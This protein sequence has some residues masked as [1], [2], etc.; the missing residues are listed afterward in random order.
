MTR[1][2]LSAVLA[3]LVAAG[4][5][6]ADR[7]APK[8]SPEKPD[9]RPPT[10]RL[11]CEPCRVAAGASANVIAEA[12][13]PDGDVVSFR[14]G[15]AAGKVVALGGRIQWTAPTQEGPVP[16]TVEVTDGRGGFATDAITLQ[17]LK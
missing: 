5:G 12:N 8:T 2:H 16:I 3:V 1:G 10:V 4:A 6:C 15:A 11:R 14:W 9:N 17:V 13:D 7:T